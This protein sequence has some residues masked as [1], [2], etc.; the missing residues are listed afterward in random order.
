MVISVSDTSPTAKI[1]F[2]IKVFVCWNFEKTLALYGRW[3]Q[4]TKNPMWINIHHST[5]NWFSACYLLKSKKAWNWRICVP[6]QLSRSSDYLNCTV[7]K[8]KIICSNSNIGNTEILDNW[9]NEGAIPSICCKNTPFLH[10]SNK[11]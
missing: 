11:F 5:N 6:M 8:K 7:P 4:R 2:F 3:D 9:K 10:Y 1:I